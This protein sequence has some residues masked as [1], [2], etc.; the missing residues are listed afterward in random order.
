MISPP[1]LMLID[2]KEISKL[3]CQHIKV[4]KKILYPSMSMSSCVKTGMAFD[5][6]DHK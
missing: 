2:I 1:L 6:M 4:Q 3:P 5:I